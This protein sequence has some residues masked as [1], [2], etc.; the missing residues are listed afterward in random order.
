[1][2]KGIYIGIICTLIVLL[3]FVSVLAFRKTEK[4]ELLV[5]TVYNETTTETYISVLD[6]KDICK[7]TYAI[8]SS[9]VAQELYNEVQKHEHLSFTEYLEPKLE[10]D[11]V[12]F[13]SLK[14]DQKTKAEIINEMQ[15]RNYESFSYTVYSL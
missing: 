3:I 9:P 14:F 12:Y 1:M 11:T 10:K 5:C 13:V 8:I 6:E 7:K 4:G 15:G 2:K